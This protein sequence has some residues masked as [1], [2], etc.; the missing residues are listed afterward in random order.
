MSSQ[1]RPAKPQMCNGFWYLVRK[2]PHRCCHIEPRTY[3]KWSTGIRILDDLKAVVA[4]TRVADL[5]N[6]MI[7]EGD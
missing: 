1:V 7:I 4:H 5:N 6:P 3:V 2:V